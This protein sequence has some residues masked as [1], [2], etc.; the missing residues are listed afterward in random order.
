MKTALDLH[1]PIV[2][3]DIFSLTVPY[4]WKGN[5]SFDVFIPRGLSCK[6]PF[7]DPDATRGSGTIC[8]VT[9]YVLSSKA[10]TCNIPLS[11]AKWEDTSL[12][13]VSHWASAGYHGPKEY[14]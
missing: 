10:V 9:F 8:G 14:L 4:S 13:T 12:V 11:L 1:S 7:R 6:I 5:D 3:V 2:M